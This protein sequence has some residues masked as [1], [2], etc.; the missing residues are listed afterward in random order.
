M[1]TSGVFF[2]ERI[3]SKERGHHGPQFKMSQSK[4][5]DRRWSVTL[6]VGTVPYPPPLYR[7][8]IPTHNLNSLVAMGYPLISLTKLNLGDI[9]ER[10]TQP[11]VRWFITSSVEEFC[12]Y[13]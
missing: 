10:D 4:S 3:K 1:D 6:V 2:T 11:S 7:K 8:S 13:I 9:S 12:C 5:R